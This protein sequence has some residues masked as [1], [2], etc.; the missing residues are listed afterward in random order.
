MNKVLLSALLAPFTFD[1]SLIDEQITRRKPGRTAR[2]I[3]KRTRGRRD[4]SQKIRANR[5]KALRKR[6]KK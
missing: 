2:K 1:T 6:G 3:T 4:R 5:R